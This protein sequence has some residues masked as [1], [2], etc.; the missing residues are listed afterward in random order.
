[1]ELS[2]IS[3]FLDI[4]NRRERETRNQEFFIGT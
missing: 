3:D 2:I 1:M 4:E